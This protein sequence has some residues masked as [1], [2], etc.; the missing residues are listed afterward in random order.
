MT[1]QEIK[2][3]WDHVKRDENGKIIF[4]FN[5]DAKMHWDD[6]KQIGWYTPYEPVMKDDD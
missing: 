1:E 4:K 5:P 3:F 2:E 6:E